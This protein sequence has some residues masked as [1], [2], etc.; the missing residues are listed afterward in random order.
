MSATN[1]T[2]VFKTPQPVQKPNRDSCF[3]SSLAVVTSQAASWPRISPFI[4]PMPW[5]PTMRQTIS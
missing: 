4:R 2:N 1:P 5:V 3:L